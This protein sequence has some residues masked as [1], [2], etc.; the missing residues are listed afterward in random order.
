[1]D[2]QISDHDG[3]DN[4]IPYKFSRSGQQ[5]AIAAAG[6]SRIARAQIFEASFSTES[7]KS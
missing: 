2:V 5:K 1:M 3:R 6:F 7:A 4:S